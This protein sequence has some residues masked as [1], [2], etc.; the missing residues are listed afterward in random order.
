MSTLDPFRRAKSPLVAAVT[1]RVEPSSIVIKVRALFPLDLPLPLDVCG[2]EQHRYI[3]DDIH[4]QGWSEQDRFLPPGLTHALEL[5]CAAFASLGALRSAHVGQGAASS[6][7]PDVRGDR[8]RWLQAGQS[9]AC[10][11]FLSTMEA[12]RLTLNREL[13]LGLHEYE[14]HFAFYAPGAC[15]RQHRDQF[16]HDDSRTVTVIVYLNAGWLPEHGGALRLHPAGL[17]ARDVLP[18]GGRAV[19]FP[20]ASMLHEVLPATRGRLSIAGWFRRRGV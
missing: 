16:R 17:S 11:R 4:R 7:Q 2:E 9:K 14:G 12:L 6:H 13:F 8:I 3:A 18:V 15:Y 5:E 1:D 19:A 20:S 10:D